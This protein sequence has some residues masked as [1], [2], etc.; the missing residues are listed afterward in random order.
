MTIASRSRSEVHAPSSTSSPA[1]G[2]RLAAADGGQQRAVADDVGVAADGRG[3]VA[4]GGR[5]QA[6]VAEVLGRVVGLLERAQ[7]ERAERLAPVAG[8]AHVLLDAPRDLPEQLGCLRGGHVL[9]QRR[10]G[11][12][13]RGELVGEA[14][15][16]LGLGALVDAVEARH[17]ALLEQRRDG[18]VGGDHQVLDQAVGLGLR[19]REDRDDVAVLVEREL[20]LLGVDDE[21]AAALALALERGGGLRARRAAARPTARRRTRRP[22]KMRSTRS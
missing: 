16:A 14:L 12:L 15:D 22:A 6:G 8:A 17:A 20:G 18:L 4:V 1:R 2:A 9:G 13:E 7:H 21:R 19:A 5:V 10:R 3:E 11:H